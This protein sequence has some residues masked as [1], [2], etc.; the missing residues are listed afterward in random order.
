ML[1]R[2]F[3]R[4]QHALAELFRWGVAPRVRFR[5][6]CLC[7]RCQIQKLTART[8]VGELAACVYSQEFYGFRSQHSSLIRSEFCV[9]CP[10]G[11]GLILPRVAAQ[12]P[13]GPPLLSHSSFVVVPALRAALSVRCEVRVL[14]RSLACG[15]SAPAPLFERLPCP[16]ELPCHLC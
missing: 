10:T 15:Y 16:R 14:A 13:Q 5:F 11:S 2:S 7:F 8:D 4:A 9:W 12:F 6:C 1:G 3:S